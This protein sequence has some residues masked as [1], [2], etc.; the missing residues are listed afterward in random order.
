MHTRHIKFQSA[1]AW[2]IRTP[3]I[4]S[5]ASELLGYSTTRIYAKICLKLGEWRRYY[6]IW[7]G[8]CMEW[9]VGGKISKFKKA[10]W[11]FF[12]LTA[13]LSL[14]FG[15]FP[16]GPTSALDDFFKKWQPGQIGMQVP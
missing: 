16:I 15:H 7:E 2:P 3:A 10:K 1:S 12:I 4:F 11:I 14:R 6:L 5:L 9:Y 8:I 13:V